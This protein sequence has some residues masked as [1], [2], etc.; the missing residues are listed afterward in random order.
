MAT[1]AVVTMC[2]PRLLLLALPLLLLPI[3]LLALLPRRV[4]PKM[5]AAAVV[6]AGTATVALMKSSRRLRFGLPPALPC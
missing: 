6:A 1:A 4:G 5:E 2:P 3:L